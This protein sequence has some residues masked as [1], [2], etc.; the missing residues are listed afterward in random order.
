M[1][2]YTNIKAKVPLAWFLGPANTKS[3]EE[4]LC[5]AVQEKLGLAEPPSGM[6]KVVPLAI[7]ALAQSLGLPIAAS[8]H[9]VAKELLADRPK[10]KKPADRQLSID[11]VAPHDDGRGGL[12]MPETRIRA[13]VAVVEVGRGEHVQRL[14]LRECHCPKTAA[15]R[16]VD[17]GWGAIPEPHGP[18]S[19]IRFVPPTPEA[20]EKALTPFDDATVGAWVSDAM[21]Y[22]S[23]VL[24]LESGRVLEYT[25]DERPQFPPEGSI[26]FAR[27]GFGERH[28][29]EAAAY[30]VAHVGWVV[31][32]QQRGDSLG[33]RLFPPGTKLEYRIS[34]GRVVGVERDA[35]TKPDVPRETVVMFGGGGSG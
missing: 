11:S 32:I 20:R 1:S 30:A 8:A 28:V 24:V 18:A 31:R 34:G 23:H 13:G 22:R 6:A 9:A 15:A 14:D 29:I 12:W 16:A 26:L 19:G 25:D 5:A 10:Q 33:L 4:Q 17:S 35:P 3:F 7:L 21:L 27:Y 2:D